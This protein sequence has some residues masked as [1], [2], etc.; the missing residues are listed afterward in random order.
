MLITERDAEIE[1]LGKHGLIDPTAF[2]QKEKDWAVAGGI[3]S[4]L[5]GGAAGV[6][7]AA[8]V[9]RQNAQ[10]RAN[11]AQMAAAV[12]QMNMVISSNILSHKEN[13]NSLSAA[14][15]STKSKLV[16]EEPEDELLERIVFSDE[17]LEVTKTGAV[18]IRVKAKVNKA[19][20]LYDGEVKACVDGV[21]KA[22][23]IQNG[24]SVGFAY[25][26]LPKYGLSSTSSTTTLMGI[27][28]ST[29]DK[30]AGYQVEYA[31]YALWL[32]ER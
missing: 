23:L 30:N 14:I 12:G 10:I 4:G 15:E 18:R 31:P 5:A 22:N 27:C 32:M 29:T 20:T 16:K 8:D 24:Q 19:I 1:W 28:T 2:Q 9:Q 17:K 6:A 3:A 21:I 26:T 7:T 13:L 11:N 25:L